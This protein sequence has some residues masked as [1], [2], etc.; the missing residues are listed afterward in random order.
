MSSPTIV[1]STTRRRLRSW[2]AAARVGALASVFLG[3]EAMA[4]LDTN[5]PLQNVMLLV[6]TSGSMAFANDGSKVRCAEVDATLAEEPKGTSQKDRWTQ[7]VE[8]LTGDVQGFNC[9]AQDRASAAFHDEFAMNGNDSYD[10]NYHVPYHRI[11]SG[12]ASSNSC[13]IAPGI[14]PA[15]PLA[16]GT[17]PF[18]YHT[19]FSPAAACTNFQQAQTGLLDSYR[20]RVRFGLMTFDTSVDAGTGISG[21]SSADYATGNAGTWSYFLNWRGN[22]D[23]NSNASC[24]K[25]RPAG[26]A[27]TTP[28]EVGARNAGAPPWEGRMVPFG[29]PSAALAAMQT[30]NDHIQQV[31]LSVRPFGATPINGLLS[32][33][34]D[35]FR[36]DVDDD[37][38]NGGT[39][40]ATGAGDGC[41]GPKRDKFVS[42]GCRKNFIIL[43]TDGEP[44]LDLRPHC[45]GTANGHDGICPYTDKSFEIVRS[46]AHPSSG[47]DPI[48]TFVVGF[49]VSNVDAGQPTPVDCSAISSSGSTFDPSNLCGPGH[50]PKLN[51]CCTLAQIAF[52][53]GTNNAYFAT[54]ATTL[55]SALS[56]ILRR[57]YPAVSTRTMPVFAQSA[58]S[59]NGGAFTFTS[60]FDTTNPDIWGG[61][62]TRKRTK[63]LPTPGPG[64]STILEATDVP[65]KAEEGDFFTDNLNATDSSHPRNFYTVVADDVGGSRFS[66]RSIRPS[67]TFA[68]NPDGVGTAS[69]TAVKGTLSDFAAQVP[70]AAMN[71]TQS[72]CTAPTVASADACASRFMQW[73]LGADVG[74]G[75][76]RKNRLGAIY[77]SVP[78]IVTAP[79]EFLRD[80]SYQQYALAQ[81]KRPPILYT[82]TTDGQLH[83]F[84]VGGYS[85]ADT[86]QVEV[87]AN[88][89]LWSFLPP[90]VLP[91]IAAQYPDIQQV[92][93]DGAPVVKDVVFERTSAHAKS[94]GAAALWY[95]VLVSSFGSGGTGYFALDITNPV[96]KSGDANTGPKLLWQLTTD[97]AGNRLFGKRGGTPA[98]ATLFFTPIGSSDPPKEI[99]VAILP[100]GESD[101]PIAGSC[102][103][104]AT[105]ELAELVDPAYPPRPKVRCWAEDAARSLTVVRLDNGEIVRSFRATRDTPNIAALLTRSR[106]ALNVYTQLNAPISGQP[107]VYPAITGAVSD[108]GYVGDRDGML[109][110][111]DFASTDPREWSMKLFFDAYSK[112]DGDPSQRGQPIATA[113]VLS[114][115]RLANV[116]IAFSTGDQETFL[117]QGADNAFLA[118]S[119]MKNYLFSLIEKPNGTKVRSEAQ[120]FDPNLTGGKRV[121]GPLSLF[122]STLFFTTYTP[123]TSASDV[124]QSGQSRLCFLHYIEPKVRDTTGTGDP[125][126]GGKPVDP[127]EAGALT[128]AIDPNDPNYDGCTDFETAPGVPSRAIVFGAGITQTPT[129]SADATYN[130]PYLGQAQGSIATNITPGSFKLV[131]QQGGT[132]STGTVPTRTFN[133]KQPVASTRIDSWAAVVE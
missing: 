50:D 90:A 43:L 71:V 55:R 8:V 19:T 16:W 117:P 70:A 76:V 74:T 18:R 40:S 42:Q 7:L 35:F 125:T 44:N 93:L 59:A 54:D 126:K 96:P 46:L 58:A 22:A 67:T 4:Q 49:A 10:F 106:T 110:R 111:L 129:C 81:A 62:L 101:G 108:R 37:Y 88:N 34:R 122:E 53:G 28:L 97:G 131:V 21:S 51:A 56:D 99:A 87:K 14:L 57:L 107:V 52:E 60:A 103:Q 119:N 123:A 69:G 3:G 1:Q 112:V 104:A 36:S 39:C 73:E 17:T 84:K 75:R 15:S 26:C 116:T 89:E 30:N 114:V 121:S 48:L 25:G 113:P 130:D 41:F 32:D 100:G 91:R 124:C 80:E 86:D 120:W 13:T 33:A 127:F 24:A 82:G 45:E 109:W 98:I 9:Y 65:Q 47:A 23:C 72:A 68:S 27:T 83:A 85:T 66:E 94:G 29:P 79:N 63:C 2:R 64:G 133:L 95:S 118:A 78:A 132:S 105:A 12:A 92:I 20:D 61:Q 11:L 31:L 38:V 6:D 128:T 77:H 102:D 115:D 5:P